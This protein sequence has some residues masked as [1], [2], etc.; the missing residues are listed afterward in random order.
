MIGNLILSL[1]CATFVGATIGVG[2]QRA[3][4]VLNA[5]YGE[6]SVAKTK[7]RITGYED[8]DVYVPSIDMGFMADVSRSNQD[9]INHIYDVSGIA[10]DNETIYDVN[11]SYDGTFE[12]VVNFLKTHDDAVVACGTEIIT[13]RSSAPFNGE[14]T[15]YFECHF[16]VASKFQLF[17]WD[18]TNYVIDAFEFSPRFYEDSSITEHFTLTASAFGY[19]DVSLSTSSSEY[20]GCVASNFLN[21]NVDLC[22]VY[23]YDICMK[24][25][26]LRVPSSVNN[27]RFTIQGRWYCNFKS[28]VNMDVAYQNGY[29]SG[30]ADGYNEGINIGSNGDFHHLFNSIADTPLRF[31]YGLFNFDLFGMSML[32]IVLTLLTGIIVFGIVKKFWK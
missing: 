30:Y 22:Y 27:I 28:S 10:A 20:H 3:N 15:Y 18:F 24:T 32:V 17:A 7:S 9:F 26:T 14:F 5:V 16:K 11:P 6:V 21:G 13:T 2:H 25:D 1:L 23:P 12:S 31:L 8:T 29:T 4:D 19:Q